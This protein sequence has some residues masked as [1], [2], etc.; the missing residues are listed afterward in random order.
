MD[1][2][3]WCLAGWFGQRMN[4]VNAGAIRLSKTSS[5]CICLSLLACCSHC[6]VSAHLASVSARTTTLEVLFVVNWRGAG[7]L[8]AA[9][10]SAR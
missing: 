1:L 3:S 4:V 6:L 2:I 5:G 7:S 10:P 8:A 9:A